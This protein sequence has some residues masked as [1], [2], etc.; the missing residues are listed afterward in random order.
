MNTI[1]SVFLNLNLSWFLSKLLPYILA[2]ILGLTLGSLINRVFKIKKKGKKLIVLGLSLVIL[3]G[4]YFA[5]SPIYQG[6][7]SNGSKEMKLLNATS[8]ISPNKL[9]VITIPN[10]PYCYEAIDKMLLLKK[11]VPS[12]EIEYRICSSDSSSINWYAEK[13]QGKI[14][15]VLANDPKA[16]SKIANHAFPAF[17]INDNNEK[18][19]I[20]TNSDFGVRALDEVE[21]RFS[22]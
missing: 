3:F 6:D 21:A 1:E 4:S 9:T 5:Y 17:V 15:V 16:V 18:L 12:L 2:P 8:E 20:W 22:N 13:G 11:R 10:C 7:F 14:D 19:L